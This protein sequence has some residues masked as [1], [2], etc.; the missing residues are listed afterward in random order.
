VRIQKVGYQPKDMFVAISPADTVP[1]TVLLDAVA[2]VLP[3][4]VTNDSARKYVSP[5]L[6]AFE[7]RRTSSVGGHFITEAELRKDD[8][9]SMTNVVRT[10]P[11][12]RVD[13]ARKNGDGGGA[14][15][16]GHRMGECWAVSGRVESKYAVLGGACEVEIYLDGVPSADH[17]LEKLHVR[18]YGAVEFYAGGASVPI[19]FARTNGTSCGV[20]LLWSRER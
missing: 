4:V 9:K 13:C 16:S 14:G 2:T 15:G 5:A 12:L 6:N 1:M 7:E 11:G 10:L 8:D 18:D 17:D 20:L 3:T 19:Q